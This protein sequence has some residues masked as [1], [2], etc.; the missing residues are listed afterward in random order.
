MS[1]VLITEILSKSK[2][3]VTEASKSGVFNISCT[4]M[5]AGEQW[6]NNF[7]LNRTEKSM[8]EIDYFPSSTKF[9][10]GDVRQVT[11]IKHVVFPAVIG[12]KHCKKTFCYY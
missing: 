12:G 1:S 11:A 2:V 4:K 6:F 9:K 10:F 5:V 3:F 7:M 8:K